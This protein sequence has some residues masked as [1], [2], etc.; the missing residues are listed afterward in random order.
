M[1]ARSPSKARETG[2]PTG[3]PSRLNVVSR[4]VRCLR[5]CVRSFVMPVQDETDHAFV[6]PT[7]DDSDGRR[8]LAPPARPGNRAGPARCAARGPRP[9]AAAAPLDLGA[10]DRAV[11]GARRAGEQAQG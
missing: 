8:P 9:R 7:L 5:N 11:R 3:V 2:V 6:T 10:A 1:N 4:T